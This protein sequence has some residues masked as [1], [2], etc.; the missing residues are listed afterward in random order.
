V[1][2]MTRLKIRKNGRDVG[3]K[4]SEETKKKIIDGVKKNWIQRKSLKSKLF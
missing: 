1:I 4:Q 2:G 3:F